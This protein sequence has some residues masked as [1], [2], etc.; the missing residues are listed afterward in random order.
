MRLKEFVLYQI[1]P[2]D[3]VPKLK[4]QLPN[5]ELEAIESDDCHIN[6]HVVNARKPHYPRYVD[7]PLD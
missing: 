1:S 4:Q 5:P 6:I 2:E 3:E 7:V